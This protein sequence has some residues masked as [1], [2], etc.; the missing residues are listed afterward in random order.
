MVQSLE[1]RVQCYDQSQGQGQRQNWRFLKIYVTIMHT[2]AKRIMSVINSM[3]LHSNTKLA[4]WRSVISYLLGLRSSVAR[5]PSCLCDGTTT[6]TTTDYQAITV[7]IWSNPVCKLKRIYFRFVVRHL[8]FPT[9]KLVNIWPRYGNDAVKS[10]FLRAAYIH[11]IFK[12]AANVRQTRV[13]RIQR[14]LSEYCIE[15]S[16]QQKNRSLLKA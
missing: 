2:K 11:I 7:K 10:F 3:L 13:R 9:C 6:T 16:L 8:E 15:T 4:D 12:C 1:F 5:L 14:G